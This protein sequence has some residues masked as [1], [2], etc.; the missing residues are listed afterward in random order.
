[1]Y[2]LSAA[3][4]SRAELLRGYCMS[5]RY[6][7]A[8]VAAALGVPTVSFLGA[9]VFGDTWKVGDHAVKIIC[10]DGYPP[11]RI[12]REVSGLSRVDSP[13]V[14]KLVQAGAVSLGGQP[15]PAL[16]FEY[17]PGGDLQQKLDARSRPTSMEALGLLQGLL[18]GLRDLHGADGTVHR[19]IKPQNIALRDGRWDLPVILDLGLA[20]STTEKTVTIYPGHIG[21]APYMAPEQL[22]ARRA[23]KAADLFAVGVTVRAAITGEHPFYEAGQHYTYDEALKQIDLGPT[24][25]PETIPSNIHNVLDLLVRPAEFER[26]SATSNLRRLAAAE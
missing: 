5:P 10:K 9:G 25:L 2:P 6:E 21:T 3:A 19:D 22:E 16:T 26:G 20:K 8:E 13:H 11:E 24:P 14:V 1:M 4:H 18:T 15:R 23:R 17:I 12:A 7:S